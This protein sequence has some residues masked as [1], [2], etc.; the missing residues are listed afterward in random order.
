M[1]TPTKDLDDAFLEAALEEVFHNAAPASKQPAKASRWRSLTVAAALLL[2]TGLVF[3]VQWLNKPDPNST[4]PIKTLPKQDPAPPAGPI[5]DLRDAY[6]ALELLKQVQT[7]SLTVPV[8][9]PARRPGTAI[10]PMAAR[11]RARKTSEL[12][13]YASR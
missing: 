10:A 1:S 8:S 4:D 13:I 5:I 12:A 11:M 7:I 9:A 3:A 6:H 2:G